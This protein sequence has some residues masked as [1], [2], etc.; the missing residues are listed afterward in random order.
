MTLGTSP[1]EL[2][3]VEKMIKSLYLSF[4]LFTGDL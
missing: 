2:M 3:L 4:A 1:C